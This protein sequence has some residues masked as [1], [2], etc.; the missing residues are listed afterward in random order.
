MQ[1]VLVCLSIGSMPP[2]W[3]AAL[4]P[5]GWLLYPS[6][7]FIFLVGYSALWLWFV[8]AQTRARMR[9]WLAAMTIL[10]TMATLV[11][12]IWFV[13]S[14]PPNFL[15]SASI[16]G[17]L[18]AIGLFCL[19]RVIRLRNAWVDERSPDIPPV[20]DDLAARRAIIHR[21]YRRGLRPRGR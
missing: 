4:Q 13:D 16:A 15:W 11:M 5:F 3:L 17:G 12:S 10:L 1:A 6:V 19:D 18:V 20:P 9:P 21:P 2:W 8:S 14:N 7:A